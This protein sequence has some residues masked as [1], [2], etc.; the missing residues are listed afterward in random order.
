M[1]LSQSQIE[2]IRHAV[3]KVLGSQGVVIRLFG[4]R[5]DDDLRGGDIDL[6][7]ETDQAVEERTLAALEKLPHILQARAIPPV[8]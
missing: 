1:R 6:L 5:A 8:V 7:V 3:R 4:S 2:S